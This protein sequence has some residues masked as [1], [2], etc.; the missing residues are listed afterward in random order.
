[1][2]NKS[3]LHQGQANL[4]GN[5]V[6]QLPYAQ[7]ADDEIDLSELVAALARRWR[8]LACITIA[9]TCLGGAI[10]VWG[11][12]T[13]GQIFSALIDTSK[14]PS[15]QRNLTQE[16]NAIAKLL[17]STQFDNGFL[18]PVERPSATATQFTFQELIDNADPN[19][20]VLKVTPAKVG[21]DT[22]PEVLLITSSA[23]NS[24]LAKQALT[25]LLQTY[26]SQAK[27]EIQARSSTSLIPVAPQYGWVQI[28]EPEAPVNHFGRSLALGLL[29]GLVIGAATALLRDRQA[30]REFSRRAIQ[31]RLG[32]PLWLDLP[33]GNA[34]DSFP[35]EAPQPLLS[36]MP[37]ELHWLVVDV[38]KPHPQ[39]SAL[40]SNLGIERGPILLKDALKATG[41][42]KIG[43]LVVSEAGFNSPEALDRAGNY[44]RQLG[45]AQ[46]ALV[47]F[48][49]PAPR[50]LQ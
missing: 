11:S 10:S 14:A 1:M 19:Q 31:Q 13:N 24:L 7:P 5:T 43:L 3:E 18:D 39:A 49:V 9:G 47:L 46:A 44:L 41:D 32:L 21:K 33:P 34:M 27:G 17:K 22:V 36:L 4:I 48:N 2:A 26:Q 30:G 25:A 42:K 35:T 37:S 8:W 15:L 23:P 38:A 16:Q 50:E 45:P 12:K 40:A 6:A 29:G 28:L 20:G